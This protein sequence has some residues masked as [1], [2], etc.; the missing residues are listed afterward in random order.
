MSNNFYLGHH[1]EKSLFGP[2]LGVFFS[3]PPKNSKDIW[4]EEEVPEGAEFDSVNDPRP[5]PEYV[6]LIL[7][8]KILLTAL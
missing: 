5:Q 2:L 6:I 4:V 7:F 8:Y 3:E 1:A